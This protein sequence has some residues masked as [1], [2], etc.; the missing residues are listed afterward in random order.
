M[1]SSKIDTNLYSRQIGTIGMET[2]KKLV[3]LKILI[4]GLRGLGIETAKNIILAGPKK[5]SLFDSEITKINDLGSN[6]FLTEEDAKHQRRRDFACLKK[7]SELN[8]NVICDVMEGEDILVNLK[9]YNIIIITEVMNKEKLFLINE[10]CRNN[11][12]GFIY[13]ASIGISGFCFVDFGKHTILDEN[14]EECKTFIIKKIASNGEIFIDKTVNKTFNISKGSY[15]VFREVGGIDELN[16]GKPRMV[17]KSTPLSIFISDSVKYE[18]YTSGG[19][20]EEVKEKK[21]KNFCSLKEKFY[22]PY[23][24]N[25]PFPFDFS[26]PGISEL[27]HCGILSLHEFYEKNNNN[28]PELNN[29]KMANEILKIAKNIFEKA[30]ANNEKWVDSI[31]TW[32][33]KIILN[34]ARWSKSEISPICSFLGGVVAQ[35]IIKYIGKYTPIDQW[36]WFE[37]SEII[38]N[39]HDNVDRVLTNSRYDDQIAI[40]GH[41]I[42]KKISESNLFMIGAGALGCEFLKNFGLMG[43]ST[44]AKNKTVVTD[45]DNIEISNLNRQFL[46]RKADIGKSKSKIACREAKKMNP[47][48]NC[49]DRQSR[50][51]P[52]NENIFDQNFWEEQTFIINAVDNIEARKY[53]DKQCTFYE[54]PLIDSGTL[55]T[56]ANIQTIIPHVTSCYNDSKKT[57]E[58][59]SN[60]IPM[61]TLRN[62]PAL[63][64]H[65][66]EWGR[67]LFIT[68]F[69]DIIIQL[70]NWGE[71]KDVFYEKL[72]HEDPFTQLEILLNI[73]NLLLIIKNNNFDKCLELAVHKYTENFDHKIRQLIIEYPEDHINKDGSKFWSGSKR[74][75][76]P[77]ICDINDDLCF[78]FIK[79]YSTILARI[80]GINAI[81][82][83]NYIKLKVQNIKIPE[84]KKIIKEKKEDNLNEISDINPDDIESLIEN[85]LQ[86]SENKEIAMVKEEINQF[87]IDPTKINIEKF[88]KDDDS[89]GHIDFIFACSN[90]RAKNYKIKEINRE[91]LKI[92]AG[93]IIPAMA[94]T[95][96]AITGIV[97]LQLYTLMQTNNI[98]F[99]R[100]CYLNLAVNRF[101]M[102]MP[103]KEIKHQDEEF[104]E[105]LSGPT[106]AIPLNW[107]VWDKIIINGSKTPKELIDFIKLEY[108][109]DVILIISNGFIIFETPTSLEEKYSEKKDLKI[110]E[111]FKKELESINSNIIMNNN[112][113][114]LQINGYYN[115]IPVLMPI[116]KY[117]YNNKEEKSR[118]GF[119]Y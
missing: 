39:L 11:K 79:N 50:I 15:L 33:D 103:S 116:F 37:F 41:D 83:E 31:R 97:C 70:K 35:E 12:I 8:P 109:V 57:D 114:I 26:K 61:C 100:N 74:F 66:I 62:F 6:F 78:M 5:V 63:I 14:G 72:K 82:D 98:N 23:I 27:I 30:K 91:K 32:N 89:N 36:F 88:E 53:I 4:I 48:F 92:I 77:I 117:N 20:C 108:G 17:M 80:L 76:H 111:I 9:N 65:C 52:E 105:E 38:G 73:K 75:P 84:F 119:V 24:D 42:Q 68:Y 40:F 81:N 2:M 28:L 87:S 93:K 118:K 104:N 99:F 51:G 3:H 59:S 96:A 55:G 113:I 16:D 47:K 69:T 107:T 115:K 49:E 19:I 34:I 43:I 45:N 67:E 1:I 7:L 44:N 95:T 110:E 54:K 64:E 102:T 29:D 85:L 25:K 112:F 60:S 90:I 106:K 101:I 18:N 71:N 56:K 46:F 13:A 86:D 94:T 21:I 10:E 58:N 22:I